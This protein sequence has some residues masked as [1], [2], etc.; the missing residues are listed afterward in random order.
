MA[1]LTLEAQALRA[2]LSKK[3]VKPAARR[4]AATFFREEYGVSQRRACA[5]ATLHRSTYAYR[6]QVTERTEAL[7]QRL[8]FDRGWRGAY[9]LNA[10]R[11]R[12]GGRHRRRDRREAPPR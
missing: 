2:A 12:E 10:V 8:A 1:D 3:M 6:C 7:R 4:E 9:L 11:T 5:M